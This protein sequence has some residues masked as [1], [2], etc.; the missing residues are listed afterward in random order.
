MRHVVHRA[1]GCRIRRA[2][3]GE[4]GIRGFIAAFDTKTGKELWRVH[5]VPGPG[6]KGNDTWGGDSWK[7]GGGSVWVTPSYDPELNL[8]YWGTGNPGPDLDRKSTRLNSSH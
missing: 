1:Q 2:A 4:F 8:M 5:T 7:T 6:E 3:G